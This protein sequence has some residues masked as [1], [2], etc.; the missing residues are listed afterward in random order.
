MGTRHRGVTQR[1]HN[2]YAIDLVLPKIRM[3]YLLI[4]L[5]EIDLVLPKIR[6]THLLIVLP[7]IDLVLPKIRMTHLFIVLSEIDLVLPKI[8]MTHML[9][10]LPEIDLV[11]PK[12]R[13]KYLLPGPLFF[14][15]ERG[16]AAGHVTWTLR[17]ALQYIEISSR[18]K[19][20]DGCRADRQRSQVNPNAS[21]LERPISVPLLKATI[22]QLQSTVRRNFEFSALFLPVYFIPPVKASELDFTQ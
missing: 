12:I 19:G 15:P 8:R 6:M 9:I 3:T 16:Q 11:L 13:M 4:V 7:E 20:H 21:M 10:V 1:L 14:C 18:F 17:T 22:L 2:H 5:P